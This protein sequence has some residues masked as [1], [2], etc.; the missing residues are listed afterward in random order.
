MTEPAAASVH[1]QEQLTGV[2]FA[3]Q[4]DEMIAAAEAS[5]LLHASLWFSFAAP[6]NLPIIVN[7]D[8]MTLS[9]AAIEA[10]TVL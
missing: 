5:Q 4:F 9:A 3:L 8:A 6:R 1:L 2:H 10:R 7:R